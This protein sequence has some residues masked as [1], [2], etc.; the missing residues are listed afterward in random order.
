MV[1]IIS[2]TILL[3]AFGTT[4]AIQQ[5]STT[6]SESE[7]A[8]RH[9]ALYGDSQS[10]RFDNVLLADDDIYGNGTWQWLDC[11]APIWWTDLSPHANEIWD[12]FNEDHGLTSSILDE[13]PWGCHFPKV[14]VSGE[15][16]EPSDVK[17]ATPNPFNPI[18]TLRVIVEQQMDA[19]VA[20]YNQLGQHV[21]TL[22]ENGVIVPG[23]YEFA[24]NGRSDEGVAVASGV[25]FLRSK[26]GDQ[27]ST[28][29]VTLL[30]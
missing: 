15:Q 3:L 2:S 6:K 21:R 19:E 1:R 10:E 27:L 17:E 28:Q 23:A 30:R 29:K 24:W 5:T 14:V 9:R 26:M 8:L 4:T 7:D 12:A 11:G 13:D 25:Y 18:V 20:V 22:R 16:A